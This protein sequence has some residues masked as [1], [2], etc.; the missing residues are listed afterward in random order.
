MEAVTSN[1]KEKIQIALGEEMA[2]LKE[3]IHLQLKEEIT[4]LKE[5]V[6]NKD[7]GKPIVFYFV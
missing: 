2:I 4:N 6:N 7:D 5:T 1:M 3:E